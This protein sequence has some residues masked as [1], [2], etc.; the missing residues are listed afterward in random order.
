MSQILGITTSDASEAYW[1]ENAR[2]KVFH[3]YPQGA[4]PLTGL[5]SL[6]G[7]EG[8]D[9]TKFGYWEDRMDP[10]YSSTKVTAAGTNG[11]PFDSWA[12]S[13]VG[14]DE[15]DP[16]SAAVGDSLAIYVNDYTQ[17]RIRDVVWVKGALNSSGAVISL[18]GVIIVEPTTDVIVIRLI[19]ALTNCAN[20]ATNLALG[21]F[22]IGSATGEGDRSKT[23]G[24]SR[25]LEIENYTQIMRTAYSLSR[26]ALKGGLRYDSE[27]EHREKAKKNALRHSILQEKSNFWGTRAT[28]NVTNADGEV[29]PEKKMGGIEWYIKQWELGNT[30]NG[31]AFDYRPGGGDLTNTAWTADDDKRM[32]D[33]QGTI[34]KSQWN[35]LMER[36]FRYTNEENFQKLCLCGSGFISV[37]SE[38]V[39]NNT[40]V[41]RKLFD[42]GKAGFSF[43]E[44]E[45]PHG[46]IMFKSHP[47]FNQHVDF[48][49]SAFFLDMGNLKY[50]YLN[51]SDTELLENRQ[52]NDADKRKDESLCQLMLKSC[53]LD[54]TLLGINSS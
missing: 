26:S 28:A 23:G 22:A 53:M 15:A 33:V 12:S 24:N 36:L 5:L 44:W 47:L 9:K 50:R 13:V 25:P 37:F 38:F 42:S 10:H 45:S 11:G 4:A 49:N 20:D 41:K 17:F 8:T 46:T 21:V 18:K 6:M 16:F 19:E 34:N 27:G 3:Q 14:T 54:Q 1:S 31:G 2:R 39:D 40:T 52:A 29:V 7:S 43:V 30:A 48:R 51:D 35:D 32:I